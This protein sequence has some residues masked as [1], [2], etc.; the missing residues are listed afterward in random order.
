MEVNSLL[1]I[2]SIFIKNSFELSFECEFSEIITWGITGNKYTC[3]PLNVWGFDES[4]ITFINGTHQAD[5]KD[6]DVKGLLIPNFVEKLEKFPRNIHEFFPKLEAVQ[7]ESNNISEITSAD[8]QN[9]DKLENFGLLS[10]QITSLPGDLFNFNSK[11]IKVAIF[12][13]HLLSH[14][15]ENILGNLKHLKG[16]N[17]LQ[18]KCINSL[19]TTPE[20]IQTL[21]EELVTKCPPLTT[22]T[23]QPPTTTQPDNDQC[24]LA[25]SNEMEKLQQTIESL[26]DLVHQN[27]EK[28]LE[29][30]KRILEI[31][32]RP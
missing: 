3:I 23:S 32:V 9:Y 13:N 30:E 5:K 21:K 16:A 22:T 10:S 2:F 29:L 14:V 15:G 31:T 18:N 25:C 28:I 27:T 4:E 17:F 20:S 24:P 6:K 26:E 12:A 7:V 8:L 11:L 19:A 1:L